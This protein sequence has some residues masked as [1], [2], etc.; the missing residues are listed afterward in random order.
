MNVSALVKLE[1]EI[2]VSGDWDDKCAIDQIY[3]QV[4]DSA[5]GKVRTVIQG[6][7]ADM[8]IVGKPKMNIMYTRSERP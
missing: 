4:A 5:I 7:S 8:E 1:V 3:K 6:H 2:A